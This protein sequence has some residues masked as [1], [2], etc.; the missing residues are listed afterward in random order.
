[1]DIAAETEHG[2][3]ALR[4]PFGDPQVDEA[5]KCRANMAPAIAQGI[6]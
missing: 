4:S 3:R 6:M 5:E 1:M 2:G